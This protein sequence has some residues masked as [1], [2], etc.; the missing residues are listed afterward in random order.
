MAEQAKFET[1]MKTVKDIRAEAKDAFQKQK[2]LKAIRSYTQALNV[3]TI[4]RPD[5]EKEE[6]EI[7]DL[8]VKVYVNLA[9]CYYKINKPKYIIGMCEVID[10]IIDINK[11]C[12]AIFYYGRAYE[13]LGKTEKAIACYKQALKLEPKNT[14]IGEVLAQIDGKNKKSKVDEKIM[15]RKAL[16]NKPEAAEKKVVYSVDD[17]FKN[18]VADMCQDLAGRS[19]FAKFDLPSGLNHDEIMCIKDLTSAFKCLEVLEDGDGKRKKISV[20]KKVL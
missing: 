13:L 11:H 14:E 3:L 1:T 12:K 8:K 20:V 5:N 9:V 7:K 6:K 4:S 17:D 15:W 10:H 16:S 18:G 19:D 2:Y